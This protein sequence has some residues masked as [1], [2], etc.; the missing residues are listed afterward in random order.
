MYFIYICIILVLLAVSVLLYGGYSI[1]EVKMSFSELI[2]SIGLI[3]LFGTMILKVVLRTEW[4]VEKAM[5]L[6]TILTLAG[7]VLMFFQHW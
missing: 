5:P 1:L 7:F 6:W 3:G 2:L 4:D